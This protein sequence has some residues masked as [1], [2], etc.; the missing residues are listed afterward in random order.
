VVRKCLDRQ[1]I[2]ACLRAG[3]QTLD[4]HAAV[5]FDV[6]SREGVALGTGGVEQALE[7]GDAC[8]ELEGGNVRRRSSEALARVGGIE[9][10]TLPSEHRVGQQTALGATQQPL[11][12]LSD[13]GRDARHARSFYQAA[14]RTGMTRDAI[15]S[16]S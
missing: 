3:A 15:P 10:R 2:H 4:A 16:R 12:L 13:L 9:V 7:L 14:P 1:Q 11:D 8:G 5:R 6:R